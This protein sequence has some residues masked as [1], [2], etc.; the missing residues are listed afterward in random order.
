[1]DD[2]YAALGCWSLVLHMSE[3]LRLRESQTR[4]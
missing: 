4:E 2:E 3:D 1:M